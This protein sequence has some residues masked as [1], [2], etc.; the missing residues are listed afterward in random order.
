MITDQPMPL[1]SDSSV[2]GF[3]TA[4]G[5]W[6][7]WDRYLTLAG[8]RAYHIGNICN[9]CAFFFTRM[10]G[11]NQSISTEEVAD[12]LEAGIQELDHPWL[13]RVGRILPAGRYFPWL[14][15]VRAT[16][17]TLGTPHDYFAT[18][19]VLLW[20]IDPFCGLPHNPRTEYYRGTSVA[21][22][23][24]ARL[25]EFI[26]PMF[27]HNWLKPEVLAVYRSRRAS[28]PM[29]TALAISLLDVKA[30]AVWEKEPDV[31]AHWCLVHYLLDGHHKLFASTQENRQ[32][33][34]LS[35]ISVNNGISTVEQI[36]QSLDA[37]CQ[38]QNEQR[39]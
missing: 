6:P 15:M 5:G 36:K 8:R 26:V 23:Q 19:Q 14:H 28:G 29:P 1:G 18:D 38:Q 22:P 4:G 16:R 20:G 13:E 27:P 7:V 17:V 12:R 30:P 3:E 25:F 10:E 9:T 11:A 21:L 24:K 34:L 39:R 2:I 37:L 33:G 32:V 31:T 35:F